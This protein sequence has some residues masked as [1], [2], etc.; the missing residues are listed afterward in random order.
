MQKPTT[1][2]TASAVS[3]KRRPKVA[4]SDVRSELKVASVEALRSR[5]SVRAV[6][7]VATRHVVSSNASTV[8][9]FTCG[10]IT[11]MVRACC[12]R[13]QWLFGTVQER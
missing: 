1:A 5:A 7:A 6:S 13:D 3:T 10:G 11:S 2:Q 9:V 12:D 8:A 4:V